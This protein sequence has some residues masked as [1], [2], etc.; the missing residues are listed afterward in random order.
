MRRSSSVLASTRA[1][2]AGRQARECE[3]SPYGMTRLTVLRCHV[4]SPGRWLGG[5]AGRVP[6]PPSASQ[7]VACSCRAPCLVIVAESQ[8]PA[9]LLTTLAK[10]YAQIA[11]G[12][13][14]LQSV[15]PPIS[16]SLL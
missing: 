15:V 11:A 7:L 5:V 1:E 3:I 16:N 10:A 13:P 14:N 2:G 6:A 8:D 4:M 9:K 12:Q